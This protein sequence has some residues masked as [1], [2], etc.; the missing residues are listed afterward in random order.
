[1]PAPSSTSNG[2]NVELPPA[3]PPEK[4]DGT[5][6]SPKDSFSRNA[7][8]SGMRKSASKSTVS[9]IERSREIEAFGNENLRHQQWNQAYVNFQ[10]AIEV[11]NDNA[12]AHLRLGLACVAMKRYSEA[13]REFKKALSTDPGIVRSAD[14]MASML[15]AGG[16]SVSAELAR[17][18]ARWTRDDV[19]DQDRLF[20][21]GAILR[22]NDD[23]RSQEILEAA[24][25][26]GPN[27]HVIALLNSP[28]RPERIELAAGIKAGDFPN[29]P[30]LTGTTR[31]RDQDPLPEL[32]RLPIHKPS[33]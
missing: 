8:V 1:M 5:W 28:N 10:N 27:D 20:L 9:N 13:V 2:P 3:P 11:A 19:K 30:L 32:H 26:L 15:G 24:D 17:N 33:R 29:Q 18:V 6:N 21:L 4:A 12:S 14:T 22:L 25:R 16:E 31:Q 23:L 7:G